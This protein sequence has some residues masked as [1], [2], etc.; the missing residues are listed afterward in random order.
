MG[1]FKN[2]FSWS[3]SREGTFDECKRKYFLHYYGSWNGWDRSAPERTRNIYM[4]KQLQT[5]ALWSGSVVHDHIKNLLFQLRNGSDCPSVDE[6][7]DKT[8]ALMRAD[9][10]SS[11]EANY[12]KKPKTL[13]LFEHEYE[14]NVAKEKWQEN[15][16]H[17]KNCLRT[18]YSSEA[19]ERIKA[20]DPCLLYTSPSPRDATLS[21]MPSSA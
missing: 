20:L 11:R 16:E 12:R 3:K 2:T 1:S 13:G 10:K 18:F 9:F 5:R 7:I 8:L 6:A 14:I 4:L 21:R 17:V 19:L 15:A